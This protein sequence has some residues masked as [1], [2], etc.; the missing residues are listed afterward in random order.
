MQQVCTLGGGGEGVR[1][2]FTAAMHAESLMWHSLKP[3]TC[4]EAMVQLNYWHLSFALNKM[5]CH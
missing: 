3:R 4:V 5:A 2:N 1:D